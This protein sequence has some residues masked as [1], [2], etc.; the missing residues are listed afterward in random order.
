[1]GYLEVSAS[2]FSANTADAL[3]GVI[4][5]HYDTSVDDTEF[6]DNSGTALWL[7]CGISTGDTTVTSSTFERNQAPE[8]AAIHLGQCPNLKLDACAMNDNVASEHGGAIFISGG[9]S[10]TL[11]SVILDGNTSGT[12][13]GAIYL[14]Q[15]AA[16]YASDSRFHENSAE[17]GGA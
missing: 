10:V 17:R 3:S 7:S 4:N 8:G 14:P 6:L 12:D 16:L 9:G 5:S 2:S 13:G 15:G 1:Q 11:S